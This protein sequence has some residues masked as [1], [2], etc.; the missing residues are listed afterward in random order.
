MIEH[1]LASQI[2]VI[3]NQIIFL[4]KRRNFNFKGITLYPSEIH[5]MLETKGEQAINAT[6]IA[7]NL[8]ITKG[9]ISQTLS[10]LEKKGIIEKEKDPYNK[11]EL[12]IILT[13]LGK[14]VY[15]Q[16]ELRYSVI[17]D[18]FTNMLAYYSKDELEVIKKFISDLEN[19]LNLI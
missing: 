2:R 15:H 4:E 12:S 10:R 3:I 1:E 8:R 6:K 16:Y 9:A 17:N 5:L 11:N 7:D 13:P 19:T 14:R 18:N